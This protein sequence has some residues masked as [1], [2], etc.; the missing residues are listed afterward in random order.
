MTGAGGAVTGNLLTPASAGATAD[1][2]P[3]AAGSAGG[4]DPVWIDSPECT[5]CDDCIEIN[6]EIFVYNDQKQAIIKN[7]LAG[8]FKEIVKAA[9]QCTAECIHPGSP[10]NPNEPGLDKL[11]KRAE[12][13]Q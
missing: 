2:A 8:T 12:K 3:A 13:F 4:N 7:P 1:S 5:A 6:P 11:I 9:E 10:A